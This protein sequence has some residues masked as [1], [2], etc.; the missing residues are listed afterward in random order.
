[1]AVYVADGTVIARGDAA[2]PEV[3]VPIVQ[4]SSIGTVG[5]D[6][7]LIDV[8]NLSS[9]AREYKKAIV[10]GQ[11]IQLS[12]QWDPANAVHVLLQETDVAAETSVNF[13]ITFSDVTP[14]IVTFAAMVTNATVAQIEID[15]VLMLNVTLKPTGALAWT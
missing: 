10:D 3:F 1:M 9:A 15:S 14:T 12:C 5:S 7:G 6:R 8:T 13:K 2:S 4:V 11:E